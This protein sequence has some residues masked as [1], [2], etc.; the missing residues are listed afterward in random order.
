MAQRIKEFTAAD[1]SLYMT[2]LAAVHGQGY[3]EMNVNVRYQAE[4]P[5]E[6]FKI[7]PPEPLQGKGFKGA[8]ACGT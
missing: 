8:A 6:N 5:G 4:S 2:L 1:T 3:T 7:L